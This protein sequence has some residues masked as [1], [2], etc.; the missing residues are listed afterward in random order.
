LPPLL[1]KRG[2]ATLPDLFFF[3]FLLLAFCL[4]VDYEEAMTT[5]NFSRRQFLQAGGIGVLGA[6]A[7]RTNAWSS[8]NHYFTLYVDT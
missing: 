5:D 7:S 6:F 3:K 4:K 1:R 8:Q 2:Q